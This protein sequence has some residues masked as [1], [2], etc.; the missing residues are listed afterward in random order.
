MSPAPSGSLALQHINARNTQRNNI[1][2]L[3]VYAILFQA[4]TLLPPPP[5][6]PSSPLI[7][8]S[9]RISDHEREQNS[10]SWLRPLAWLLYK[11]ACF[12]SFAVGP[13]AQWYKRLT[14]NW[15]VPVSIPNWIPVDFFSLYR[16]L[17][18]KLTLWC[19]IR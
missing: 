15:K 12:C 10:W 13:V 3:S 1:R 4:L 5:P 2:F 19:A 6:S 18:Q 16:S 7:K 9:A 11:E 8:C 17:S 14:S